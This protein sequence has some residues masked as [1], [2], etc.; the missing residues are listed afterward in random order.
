M[1]GLRVSPADALAQMKPADDLIV[2]LVASE[3]QW[4]SRRISASTSAGGC[5]W[6]NIGNIHICGADHG[7]R[8]MYYR[9]GLTRFRPRRRIRTRAPTC[10]R[11][12]RLKGDG[13]FSNYKSYS[14]AEHGHSVVRGHGG[15]WVMTRLTHVLPRRQGD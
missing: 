10:H 2:E 13:S 3:P 15:I 6:R 4:R 1:P 5:G 12:G 7:C 9:S 8:D 14:T 11:L